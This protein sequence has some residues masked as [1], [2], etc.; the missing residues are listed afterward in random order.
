[1]PDVNIEQ[2]VR[3]AL[4]Q[5][6]GGIRLV[7]LKIEEQEDRGGDPI[8]YI[9]AVYAPDTPPKAE[10]MLSATGQVRDGL[11]ALGETRFPVISFVSADDFNE[12]AA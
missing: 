3:D 9:L 8:F 1:M 11:E 6:D 7:A 12:E 5:G 2:A 4:E 10:W